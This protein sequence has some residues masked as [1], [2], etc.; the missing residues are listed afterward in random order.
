MALAGAWQSQMGCY[1]PIGML[2]FSQDDGLGDDGIKSTSL[3]AT[4]LAGAWQSQMGCEHPIGI[5]REA[6]D[7]G[8]F[9]EEKAQNRVYSRIH[10]GIPI[11]FAITI[12]DPG[13][14]PGMVGIYG[15]DNKCKS[16]ESTVGAGQW[17]KSHSYAIS[18]VLASHLF[19]NVNGH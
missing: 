14:R 6:Q 17:A 18:D 1:Y 19:E 11:D 4:A 10:S 3:R 12:G 8:I 16:E 5:L 13:S 15:D 9:S 2:R 7:D